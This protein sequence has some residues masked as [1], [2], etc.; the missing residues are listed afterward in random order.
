[1]RI[2]NNT[3]INLPLAVWLLHD[4]YDYINQENY[5]SVTGLMK[6]LKQTILTSRI[7]KD[8]RTEDVSDFVARTL[9]HAIHDSIEKAWHKGH[10]RSMKLLGYP[11]HVI[12]R[13]MINPTE[14]QLRSRNDPIP[15][16]M[17]QRE[18]REVIVDGVKFIIGGK[19]DMVAD[20]ELFDNKSTSAYTWL[21]GTR[22][23]DNQQ[24]G[25]LYKWLNPKKITGDHIHINYI[26]TDWS[27]MQ[28]RS[29]PKYPQKRVEQKSIPLWSEAETERWVVDRLRKFLAYKDLPEDQIPECNDKELWRSDPAYKYYTDPAKISGRSTK[30][31]SDKAEADE[32]MASKGGKGVVITVPG[33]AKACNYC[34]A[35]DICKQKDGYL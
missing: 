29:N 14:E 22:D 13:I 2:T 34:N 16:Y 10:A 11:E 6:P 17:E 18:F 31:F 12:E 27:R 19:Y 9:G 7:P 3:G 23:D 5:I 32:F 8:Q 26:F 15:V 24:Q 1:M 35:F 28:A 25:S 30:N 33:E 21:F 20:G 4:E